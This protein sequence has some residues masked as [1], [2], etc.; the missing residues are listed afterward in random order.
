MNWLRKLFGG[1]KSADSMPPRYNCL[2]YL[3]SLDMQRRYI[4]HATRDEYLLPEELLSDACAVVRQVRTRP[5]DRAVVSARA[6]KAIFA[7]EPLV[8]A[9]VLPPDRDGL[10]HLVERDPA[11]RALREQAARCLDILGFDLAEWERAEISR[12]VA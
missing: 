1:S 10:Q 8:D 2:A 3:A 6:A 12:H 9:V 7:L 11:W 4:V 5:Q